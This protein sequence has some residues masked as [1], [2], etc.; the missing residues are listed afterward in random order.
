M[1]GRQ[2]LVPGAVA[3]AGADGSL[4][5]LVSLPEDATSV[6][7]TYSNGVTGELLKSMPYGPQA[8]GDMAFDWTDIP[9]DLTAART[10]IRVSVSAT[11]AQG[12]KTVSPQV[13]AR[14]LS[15][16]SG[17]TAQDLTLQVEDYGAMNALEVNSIR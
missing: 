1:L 3:R 10:P 7:V 2:V 15:A 14:V 4:H 12:T 13:Y 8:K 5:G 9:A 11:G 17:G 16:T 6:V